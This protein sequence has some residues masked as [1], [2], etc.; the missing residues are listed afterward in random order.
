[1][2]NLIKV[3]RGLLPADVVFKGG[4]LLNVF[5]ESW[6]QADLAVYQGKIAGIG[7]Y[8]GKQEINCQNKFIVPGLIEGHLHLESSQLLPRHLA[9]E[10]A[11]HGTSAIVAD[12]HEILN[13]C[14]LTGLEFMLQEAEDLPL[15]LFFT[16]SSCVPASPF[17]ENGANLKAEDLQSYWDHP[18]ILGLAEMMNFPGVLAGEPEVLDKIQAASG[19]GKFIDG[20]APGLSGRDLNAYVAAGI[21]SDHEC[22]SWPEAREKLEL[23][24]WIMIREGSAA[25]NLQD[26]L[27]LW[28]SPYAQRCML[29]SDDLAA[30]TLVQSGHLDRIIRQALALG[31]DPIKTI[32]MASFNPAQYFNLAQRGALAPG[33][34]ADL[35]VLSDLPGFVLEM[36]Y[37]NGQPIAPQC[38]V[39]PWQEK[40]KHTVQIKPPASLQMGTRPII[41]MTAG[42][43]LTQEGG[44]AAGIDLEQDVLQVEVWERYRRTGHRCGA[45]L[46]GYGLQRGAIAQSISHDSHNLIGVGTNVRDLQMAFERLQELQGGVVMVLEGQVQEELALPLGGL[47]SEAPVA[48]VI[49]SWQRLKALAWSWGVRSELDPFM[50]LS[51]LAL[52]VIPELKLTTQG[53][54]RVSE[55]KWI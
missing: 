52:P 43:L 2:E 21:Y 9:W 34:R 22:I 32:K 47:M 28:E 15:D 39:N 33:Y 5:T 42:Q 54:V 4:S 26:L 19:R 25:R 53:L 17:E 44:L 35:L 20:H 41:Q 55:F 14:G 51:F 30:E 8:Q 1:M 3:A 23:G 16:L 29:V 49:A 27:P 40:I 31:M 36:V 18:R 50:A 7:C 37:K 24:Q 38:G 13:V 11:R 48:E 6:V 12:P 10:A 45:Y 46:Q